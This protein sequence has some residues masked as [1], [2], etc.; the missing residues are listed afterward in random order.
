MDKYM[1]EEVLNDIFPAYAP[2]EETAPII[3]DYGSTVDLTNQLTEALRGY[4]SVDAI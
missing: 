1:I 3:L 4:V 2:Y